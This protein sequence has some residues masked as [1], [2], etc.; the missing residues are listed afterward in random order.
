ME[1]V[2]N[3]ILIT[4]SLHGAKKLKKDLHLKRFN[5]SWGL[6]IYN[7]CFDGGASPFHLLRRQN[8][9]STAPWAPKGRQ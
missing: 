1:V 8:K 7:S 6:P 3:V 9:G 2:E 5:N 4:N